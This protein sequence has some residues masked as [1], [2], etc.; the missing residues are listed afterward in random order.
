MNV[1]TH[2]YQKEQYLNYYDIHNGYYNNEWRSNWKY[3]SKYL[4]R[5]N[6]QNYDIC[7]TLSTQSNDKGFQFI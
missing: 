3:L 2:S 7:E 1:D 6:I 4:Y 5:Q